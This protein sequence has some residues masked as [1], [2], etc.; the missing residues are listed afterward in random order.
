MFAIPAATGSL[1]RHRPFALFW[2]G[3]LLSQFGYQMQAVA[4]GW[5]VYALTDSPL[6]LGLV[7]L[8]QYLPIISLVLVVGHVADRYDRRITIPLAQLAEAVC[9]VLLVA[10]AWHGWSRVEPLFAIILVI[11]VA[12]A[13]E[14]PAMSATLPGLVGDA[15]LQEAS[16]WSA[17]A[18]QTATIMGPAAGGLLY[19]FGSPVPFGVAAACFAAAAVAVRAIPFAPPV[20]KREP[21]SWR[22]MFSGIAFIRG[23]PAVLGAISLDLFAVLLGGATALLPI[24]AR[25]IL[26]TGPWGLGVLRAAPAAGALLMSAA[27]LR[28]PLRRHAGPVMF[29]AV[30]VF[31]VATVVFAVS[32]SVWLSLVALATLGAADVVSVVIRFSLVQMRTPEAMRGRVSAVNAL[33]IGTSNQL[34]EFESG[35]TAALFGTVP[36]V[37]IGGIGTIGVAL[38]WMR[39]FPSLRRIDALE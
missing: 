35:T 28:R 5:E 36:A 7:G 23:N 31:G 38:L 27:L 15:R 2:A 3:R 30:A 39:L 9:A 29:G 20:A 6:A 21:A 22:S 34:G 17:S 25:D 11:G 24:F 19:A 37:L 26:H 33:F 10:G 1:F 32:Q 18:N 16:A 14:S 13:F 8:V 12:R 4:I